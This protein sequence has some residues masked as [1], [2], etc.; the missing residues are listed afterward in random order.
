MRY[1]Y[2]GT[3][4]LFCDVD[5]DGDLEDCNARVVRDLVLLISHHNPGVPTRPREIHH[6][7]KAIN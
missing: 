2:D 4:V 3:S 5:G 7:A 6:R 1:G